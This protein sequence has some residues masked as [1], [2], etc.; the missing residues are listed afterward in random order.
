MPSYL[1]TMY[2]SDEY[3]PD[4][5]PQR[6]CNYVADRY[7]KMAAERRGSL[8]DVGS[9]KGNHLIA[10]SR[11]GFSVKGLD[12]RKECLGVLADFD[13]RECNLETHA[14]PF[15][16]SSFDFVFSKSVLE[17]VR[18]TDHVVQEILR[19]LKPGGVTVH[20]TPDWATDYRVFWDDPTHVKPFTRRGLRHAFILQDFRDVTC[21]EF[22]QLPFVWKHPWLVFVPR[23]VSLLPDR[24]KWKDRE[25]RFQNV[26]V[27]HS[28]ER[29]LLVSARKP[30]KG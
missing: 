13:I 9:G 14:F 16:D 20:L 25:Q 15:G 8:L 6:L 22:Y 17:H 30:Q 27:R 2:F 12:I 11:I 1:E 18:N 24:L 23:L 7:F 28:K 19:V 21:A 3:A 29:M 4:R 5:Y 10:F 26:L